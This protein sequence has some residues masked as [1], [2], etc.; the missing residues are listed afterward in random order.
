VGQG[1]KRYGRSCLVLIASVLAIAAARASAY[2]GKVDAGFPQQDMR[3]RM[4]LERIR[5]HH[6]GMR[7][8]DH[9]WSARA[10]DGRAPVTRDGIAV[11]A[12]GQ[13][14]DRGPAEPA[15][16]P[17][18]D[19]NHARENDGVRAKPV[20][21][22]LP[23]SD[24]KPADGGDATTSSVPPS[25]AVPSSG[26][27]TPVVPLSTAFAYYS[28]GDLD[29]H[30]AT[31][32]RK[33]DRTVYLP[34]IIFPL[35][36]APDQHPHMN[37]QIWGHGGSGWNGQG[38]AG[39]SECDPIN[40]D[41]MQQR[42]TYCEVRSWSMPMCP[43]GTGHQGQDIRPPT[44]KNNA[45]NVVAVVDGMITQ[46]TSNTTVRLKGG[47]GTDYFYLHMHPQSITV[48]VGQT[49]KQ[50]DVLGHVSSYMDGDPNGTTIHLH[51]QVRQT[52]R[53]DGKIMSVY[54]PPFTSLIAAYRKAKGLDPGI[55]PDGN[56]IV[57]PQREITAPTTTSAQDTSSAP[58]GTAP[59]VTTP[60]TTP[61]STPPISPASQ[62]DQSSAPG[63]GPA[64]SDTTTPPA[65]ASAPQ[66]PTP[67][68]ATAP[69]APVTPPPSAPSAAPP[70]AAAPPATPA[71]PPAPVTAPV[72]SPSMPTPST[73]PS[74]SP[75]SSSPATTPAPSAPASGQPS[76]PQ[77]SGA[78]ASSNPTTGALPQAAAP[79]ASTP[80]AS[81]Q[82]SNPAG[83][84]SQPWW[85]KAWNGAKNLLSSHGK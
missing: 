34:N 72:G 2:P 50:G 37:S 71:A 28:P 3:Q 41:P 55:G 35:Q 19:E 64:T 46:V 52:I 80:P 68:S 77:P 70:T 45:W 11:A 30:D 9:G 57:D 31:R 76:A 59:P 84:S 13:R 58:S 85:Q 51:F 67:P 18:V 53:V 16:A 62:P 66:P 26:S 69:A 39:G 32:G 47:D 65:P 49:V 38:G 20:R 6:I 8:S 36:L 83:S 22:A 23:L 12:A 14:L 61:P 74:A 17:C 75:A 29:P 81:Q 43:G 10:I 40:Y 79:Q 48:K 4:N 42:D 33:G 24:G 73:S 78:P 25:D 5:F 60:A 56:L 27:T 1:S 63:P 7:S 44:C 15:A 54:V 21:C 82:P